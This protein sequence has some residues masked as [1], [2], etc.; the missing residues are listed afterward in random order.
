MVVLITN[1]TD[2][3]NKT[4]RQVSIYT[5]LLAPG[6]AM[7]LAAQFVDDKLRALERAGFI[8][9]GPVPPWYEEHKRRRELSAGDAS[10]TVAVAQRHAAAK[11]EALATLRDRSR[12]VASTSAPA[13]TFDFTDTASTED[14]IF[15]SSDADRT[16]KRRR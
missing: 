7:K 8:A 11:Q 6:Q 9:I 1:L 5:T 2:A 12:P 15:V 16:K 10:A 3:A 13:T 4:P 14:E